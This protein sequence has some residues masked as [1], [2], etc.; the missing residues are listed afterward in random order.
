MKRGLLILMMAAVLG[1]ASFGAMRWWSVS[2]AP[3]DKGKRGTIVTDVWPELSWLR[4]EL[5]LTEDQFGRVEA[6]HA[7]YR[8]KCEGLCTRIAE[9]LEKLESL[10]ATSSAMTPELAAA[11]RERAQV[12]ADCRTAM[13]EHF[14]QTAA[15]MNKEQAAKYL[16]MMLPYALDAPSGGGRE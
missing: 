7:A 10:A 1:A 11:F 2:R 5:G 3:G 16:K 14:Y 12:H 6:L 8:P 4:N 13:L 9:S 15:C